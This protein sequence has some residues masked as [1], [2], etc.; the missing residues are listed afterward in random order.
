MRCRLFTASAIFIAALIVGLGCVFLFDDIF[1]PADEIATINNSVD[2][3]I[4]PEAGWTR[5]PLINQ[6]WPLYIGYDCDIK[7]EKMVQARFILTNISSEP[8]FFNL[9]SK[10]G[11]LPSL[12]SNAFPWSKNVLSRIVTDHL[13]PG[14]STPMYVPVPDDA[15]YFDLSFRVSRGKPDRDRTVYWTLYSDSSARPCTELS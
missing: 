14:E 5:D 2:R 3:V 1:L 8:A 6:T 12:L 10:T 13:S 15:D 4:E 9:D 7:N 11:K